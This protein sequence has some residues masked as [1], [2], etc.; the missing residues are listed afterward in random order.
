MGDLSPSEVR[1][2]LIRRSLTIFDSEPGFGNGHGHV[3]EFLL[4][5]VIDD[6]FANAGPQAANPRL[7]FFILKIYA[8]H[9]S[10]HAVV[11]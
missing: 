6:G 9:E 10:R 7:Q 11:G 4:E 2:L 3:Q 1:Q 8:L 5:T